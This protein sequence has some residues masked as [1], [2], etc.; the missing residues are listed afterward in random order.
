MTQVPVRTGTVGHMQRYVVGVV[1]VVLGAGL[2]GCSSE[3]GTSTSA[4][5]P[6]TADVCASA[7]DLRGSLTALGQVEVVQEGTE[8]LASAWAA[9]EADWAQLADDARTEYA[10]DVDG[11]QAAADAVRAAL[12][13]AQS[14]PSAQTLGTAADTVRV[15]LQDAGAL[16]DEV[17]STC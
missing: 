14:Q 2:P 16:T 3:P 12:D 7:D 15:F 8:A 9:V 4:A 10:D 17:D 5:A 13:D 1:A 11:V 6:S